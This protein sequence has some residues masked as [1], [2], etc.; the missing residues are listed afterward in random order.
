MIKTI[1]LE[2]KELL[3]RIALKLKNEEQ[4]REFFNDLFSSAE[5]KDFSR[6]L[7]ATKLLYDGKTFQ[8]IAATLGMG[9]NTI[10]KVYFK[11]RGSKI[12]KNLLI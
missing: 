2:A 5:V 6:R 7:L 4:A 10:N 3:I 8:E 12:L 9:P 1:N 11:T